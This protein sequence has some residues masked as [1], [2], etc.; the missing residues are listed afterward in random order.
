MRVPE[1]PAR[2]DVPIQAIA[3][4]EVLG[5]VSA[6]VVLEEEPATRM[7]IHVV[8]HFQHQVV[9]DHEFLPLDHHTVR[10]IFHGH[11]LFGLHEGVWLQEFEDL[12]VDLEDDE[13]HEEDDD[14]DDPE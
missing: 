12:I 5:Y 4:V 9:K 2:Q 7:I 3:A 13:E 10:E 11:N 8:G 14:V 1:R 6:D